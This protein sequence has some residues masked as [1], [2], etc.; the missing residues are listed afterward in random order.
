MFDSILQQAYED[1]DNR[2]GLSSMSELLFGRRIW[3]HVSFRKLISRLQ[4]RINK[5]ESFY[6]VFT[7][8][9]STILSFNFKQTLKH[10][11]V[12]DRTMNVCI[13][14]LY[15]MGRLYCLLAF[16]AVLCSST[17]GKSSN[18]RSSNGYGWQSISPPQGFLKIIKK[19]SSH[20]STPFP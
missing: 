18:N 5:I 20:R 11:N 4:N 3:R 9:T 2:T 16:P 7:Y 13:V 1:P 15:P 6:K 10:R 19:P 12:M 14:R 17:T 8:L